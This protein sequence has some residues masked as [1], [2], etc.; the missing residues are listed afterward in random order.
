MYCRSKYNLKGNFGS[1]DKANSK[2]FLKRSKNCRQR[3]DRGYRDYGKKSDLSIFFDMLR[4]QKNGPMPWKLDRWRHYTG[5][6]PAA[7]KGLVHPD[8]VDVGGQS[9]DNIQIKES[10]RSHL[11]CG[12]NQL[13][14]TSIDP[15]SCNFPLECCASKVLSELHHELWAFKQ[16]ETE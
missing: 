14:L 16:R 8:E 11:W 10:S 13:S 7:H 9:E 15:F 5:A 1:C 4:Q 2:T 6:H 12:Y 3:L